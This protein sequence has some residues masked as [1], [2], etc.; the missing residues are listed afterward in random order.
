MITTTSRHVIGYNKG[1][2]SIGTKRHR[3]D[4]DNAVAYARLYAL[5]LQSDYNNNNKFIRPTSSSITSNVNQIKDN[6]RL[7]TSKSYP[8]ATGDNDTTTDDCSSRRA[9]ED[10]LMTAKAMS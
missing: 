7:T 4:H 5:H 2:H 10:P 8:D 9:T 3:C 1:S 6:N